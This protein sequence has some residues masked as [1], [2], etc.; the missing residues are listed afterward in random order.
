MMGPT[1]ET[2]APMPMPAS[3]AAR[4]RAVLARLLSRSR[5]TALRFKADRGGNVTLIFALAIIPIFGAVAV[6]VDYSRG[7]SAR[8]SMQAVL[9]ATT[10]MVSK[11]A[12]DLKS[13]QVQQKAKTYFNSQFARKD[14]KNLKLTFSLTTNGPG[15]FTVAGEATAQMDTSM[16]QVI[17]YKQMD[18]RTTSQVRWGFKALELALALDNTGSMAA[19]NKMVELKAAVKL[20]FAML[21]KNSKVPDDTKIAVIPF[22]TVVNIGTEYAGKPW[23]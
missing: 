3:L 12:L 5:A 2:C 21:K 4:S 7:N 23:V 11:E 17:G 22:N 16:A 18:L 9:D 13:G 14:V 20:L 10:L 8:T 15:D 1:T 19:K 6:A